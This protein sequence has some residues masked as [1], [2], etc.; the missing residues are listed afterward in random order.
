MNILI[1]GATGYLGPDLISKL[2][3]LGF[4]VRCLVRDETKLQKVNLEHIRYIVGDLTKPVTIL[5]LT[6][7]IYYVVH[8]A[9]LGHSEETSLTIENYRFVNVQGTENLF[10]EI[11]KH[12]VKKIICF[13]SSA[14][15]GIPN[16]KI[17][18]EET[19]CNPQTVYGISK[20]ESDILIKRYVKEFSLPIVTLRFTHVYGPGDIR[21]FLKIVKLVKNG[22]FPIVGFRAN[23]YPA[24]YKDDAIDSILLTLKNGKEGEFYNISDSESHDMRLIVKYI[25]SEL[26]IRRFP[27]WLP[28]YPTLFFLK[29][30]ELLK[31]NFPVS[32]KNI[33]FV[34]SG[35]KYSIN[36]ARKEL[37]FIP[38][39]DLRKGIAKTVEY[40][41]KEGLI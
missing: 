30:L 3:P 41:K 5:D 40:Y 6:K 9:V 36:R 7:N 8:L 27:L 17:I 19:K 23:L 31:I 11:I 12:P 26:G 14:A 2:V 35:R 37:E 10:K 4:N 39:V 15:V 33:K 1:T 28:K 18:D 32:S 24:I 22:V 21:D 29:V 25:K 16:I 34:T 20:Y 38:Q 13:S